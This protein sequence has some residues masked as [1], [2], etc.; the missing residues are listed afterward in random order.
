MERTEDKAI[1]FC[2]ECKRDVHLVTTDAEIGRAIRE[3]LC[4]AWEMPEELSNYV[5]GAQRMLGRPYAQFGQLTRSILE[6]EHRRRKRE[7]AKKGD[8]D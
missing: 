4:I 2:P 8:T 3:D 6:R 5:D 7:R 1:R